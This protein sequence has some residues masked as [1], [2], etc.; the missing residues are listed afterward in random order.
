[1]N[2]EL[3]SSVQPQLSILPSDLF[4]R[5]VL[6]PFVHI[7]LLGY[8]TS[9]QFAFSVHRVSTH[10]RDQRH[11]VVLFQLSCPRQTLRVEISA[12]SIGEESELTRYAGLVDIFYLLPQLC[13][14]NIAPEALEL[15]AL[16]PVATGNRALK[17]SA[18]L[19]L[20][21]LLYPRHHL[22]VHRP[23]GAQA[24]EHRSV[25][26]FSPVSAFFVAP[27]PQV[28]G[29]NC[30]NARFGKIDGNSMK[31][32]QLQALAAVGSVSL[33]DCPIEPE[34]AYCGKCI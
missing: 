1:M 13:F 24:M 19:V 25:L 7:N 31:L 15:V 33:A 34:C 18:V 4:V 2:E 9:D 27:E 23:N 11:V 14:R 29:D 32:C 22:I 20:L 26:P 16:V 21:S 30:R 17:A 12:P 6:A 5:I 28:F 10:Q 3:L 8:A